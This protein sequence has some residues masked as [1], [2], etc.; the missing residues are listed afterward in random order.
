MEQFQDQTGYNG[1]TPQSSVPAPKGPSLA[2]IIMI[3]IVLSLVIAI[4]VN[5]LWQN[6]LGSKSASLEEQVIKNTADIQAVSEKT[7]YINIKK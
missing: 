5:F 4:G 1:Q 2:L 7:K 3:N 6:I